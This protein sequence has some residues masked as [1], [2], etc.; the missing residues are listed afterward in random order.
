MPNR[1]IR[2]IIRNQRIHTVPV[3]ATVRTAAHMMKE[4]RI[5]ALMVVEGQR[6]LGIFTERDALFRVLAAGLDPDRTVV[7]DVMTGDPTTVS[8]DRPI[9]HALHLMHDGGFRHMPVTERG[10]PVGMVSIRD[11][12]GLELARFEQELH[13]RDAIAEIL[14]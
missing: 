3:S 9:L 6:L 2:T 7:G 11:A 12:M 5:G 8:P 13:E 1:P 14:A 4:Y 10:V